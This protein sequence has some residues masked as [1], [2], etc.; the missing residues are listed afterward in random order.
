MKIYIVLAIVMGLFYSSMAVSVFSKP[1]VPV[2]EKK[3]VVTKKRVSIK[4]IAPAVK[5]ALVTAY[6][7]GG[8]VTEEEILMNCPS[9]KNYPEGRTANGTVPVPYKTV[10]CDRANMG[11]RFVLAGIGEVICTDTGGAIQGE[12]RFDLYVS[13]VYEARQF[14]K[15][16]IQYSIL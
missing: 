5:M 10:A 14:G 12:G 7:C 11:R 16:K 15:Q 8:L 3:A 1:D 4:K 13:D 9:L 6:S 2:K